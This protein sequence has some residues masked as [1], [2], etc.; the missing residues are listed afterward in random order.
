[1]EELSAAGVHITSAGEICP[2][3]PLVPFLFPSPKADI[4]ELARETT[5]T[6][7]ADNNGKV[8]KDDNPRHNGSGKEEDKPSD[9]DDRKTFDAADNQARVSDNEPESNQPQPCFHA[10]SRASP[11][12][13]P[14]KLSGSDVESEVGV[15][16]NTSLEQAKYQRVTPASVSR[17]DPLQKK[18]LEGSYFVISVLACRIF[19]AKI[20]WRSPAR[21]WLG[22]W[23]S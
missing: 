10:N 2:S 18:K 5:L 20:S 8:Q 17:L 6:D 1:M 14:T 9:N 15:A 22:V 7:R 21:T 11:L 16:R 13:V 3:R 4:L 23:E 19:G 12:V